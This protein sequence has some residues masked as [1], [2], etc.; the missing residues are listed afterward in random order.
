MGDLQG[1]PG[2]RLFVFVW[3]C[4]CLYGLLM[5]R[6]RVSH[7]HTHVHFSPNAYPCI[8][9]CIICRNAFNDAPGLGLTPPS[10]LRPQHVGVSARLT[11]LDC[12]QKQLWLPA[13]CMWRELSLEVTA[14]PWVTDAAVDGN[15]VLFNTATQTTSMNWMR[16]ERS[17]I[18]PHDLAIFSPITADPNPNTAVLGAN[19]TDFTLT[20]N[21]SRLRLTSRQLD[22]TGNVIYT[23]VP[24]FQV[25]SK[26]QFFFPISL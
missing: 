1:G 19:S 21:A 9:L 22:K 7:T 3:D 13:Y 11:H 5:M 14:V 4:E 24:I 25:Y 18:Y 10:S 17:T 8:C 16:E 2:S 23:K 15:T 6:V 20:H 26:K 12:A